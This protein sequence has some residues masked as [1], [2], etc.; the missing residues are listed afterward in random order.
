MKENH[1][2]IRMLILILCV[3]LSVGAF[4]VPE[5][6]LAVAAH[7]ELRGVWVSSVGNIDYPLKATGD[8]AVLKSELVTLM[9]TC[10]DMGFNA[11][12][13]QVRP[14]S[15]ALYQSDIF[16]WSRYLTGAQGQ[17][18]DGGF[19]PLA[20]AIE[21]AHERGMELHAWINPY[22]ITNTPDDN[23]R[24]AET[25]P[26]ALRPE[27]TITDEKNRMFYNP[28]EPDAIDLI[29]D[30]AVEIVENY[31]VDGLHMDDYFY[32][33]GN[34]NDD[35]TYAYYQSEY[36]DK[37]NWRRAMVNRMVEQMDTAVH[38]A[39][40]DIVFSI[41]PRGIWANKD[42]M[43]EGSD[44]HGGGSYNAVFGDSLAWVKNGWVD[45]IMPQIYWS[46]G[47]AAA[48]Y[49]ILTDWWSGVVDGTDVRLYIGEAAY[50][51]NESDEK[52]WKEDGGAPELRKHIDICRNNPNISGYC[53]FS[54]TDFL[55]NPAIYDLM[56]EVN[57]E[58]SPEITPSAPQGSAPGISDDIADV[59]NQSLVGDS[60]S[61]TT[62]A[63]SFKDLDSY[64]W[65]LDAINTLAQQGII[66]GRSKTEFDPD[67]YITRADYTVLL[68]RVLGKKAKATDNFTDVYP[69]KYYYDEIA[70]AKA[71][72][73]AS[74]VGDGMFDPDAR[75]KRQDMASM[76]YR[77]LSAEGILTSIPNTAVLNQFTDKDDIDFYARDAMA[78]CVDAGLMGGYGDSTILP[79]GNASRVEVALFI[80]RIQQ[81]M[82]QK[83]A[84]N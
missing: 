42:E 64:W 53:M 6:M 78:A 65:A 77:V 74:G 24:L 15:D 3:S 54:Y 43:A 71:L 25:N 38:K 20:C 59:P 55:K 11:V 67:S 17:A 13:L 45:W 52:A 47:F 56:K 72:G 31:D 2:G 68:L 18:P 32:P 58:P 33:S 63:N 73:I 30:G 50:K 22:R 7:E 44:T 40:P 1:F 80:Y 46:V 23:S 35:G 34:I 51:T 66:K 29:V 81:L 49:R 84:Q 48:D 83:A 37:N 61:G 28:G 76:A 79:Q 19:D 70:Q 16:P 4:L 82:Q 14:C 9:D 57:A 39:N 75:V 60:E 5:S 41:S 27:L 8:S 21:L 12:F 62:D 10:K 36:P 69:G 26:A